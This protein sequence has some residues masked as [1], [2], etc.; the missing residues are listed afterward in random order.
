MQFYLVYRAHY[1]HGDIELMTYK[2]LDATWNRLLHQL[3]LEKEAAD[4]SNSVNK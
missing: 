2:E 4:K 3:Q 1:S